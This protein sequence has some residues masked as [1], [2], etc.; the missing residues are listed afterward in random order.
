MKSLKRTLFFRY[1][2]A[3][4]LV[5][6]IVILI[7][8]LSPSAPAWL[9]TLVGFA[10]LLALLF[11]VTYWT[12]KTLSSDLREIGLLE[13]FMRKPEKALAREYLVNQVWEGVFYG[14][15]KTL[16]VHIRHLRKKIEQDPAA[17][18][19]IKTCLLYTS[20]AADDLLC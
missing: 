11:G 8:A 4:S 14:S 5:F 13:L 20:D 2:V 12:E 6:V 3:A 7:V 19:Y 10:F 9:V 15:T 16:D 17:P 18:R 1:A